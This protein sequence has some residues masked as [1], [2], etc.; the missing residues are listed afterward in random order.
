[1]DNNSTTFVRMS[2]D[3]VVN[4]F[5]K[6]LIQFYT[7]FQFLPLNGLVHKHFDQ[8]N[9]FLSELGN[10]LIDYFIC[11]SNVL[12]VTENLTIVTRV[13]SQHMPVTLKVKSKVSYKTDER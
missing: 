12:P 2:D 5:G 8:R 3:P 10:S 6:R 4:S 1:M 9:T 13:E 7:A 11:G